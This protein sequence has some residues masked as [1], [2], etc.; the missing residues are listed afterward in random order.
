MRG[1]MPK[2]MHRS[3]G[4]DALLVLLVQKEGR[5][6][7][8]AKRLRQEIDRSVLNR[9][10]KGERAPA[11]ET[12]QKIRAITGGLIPV[13]WWEQEPRGPQLCITC[14]RPT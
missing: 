10:R 14:G 6:A 12:Q 8:L 4:S 9:A 7:A 1:G 3:R 2:P 5:R 11:K 13:P